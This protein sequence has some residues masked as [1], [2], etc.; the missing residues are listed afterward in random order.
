MT[1]QPEKKLGDIVNEL[2]TLD[3]NHRLVI[4]K[5]QSGLYTV[6]TI[7]IPR[8]ED[9]PHIE[10][11]LTQSAFDYGIIIVANGTRGFYPGYRHQFVLETDIKKFVMHLTSGE[12]G[13]LRGAREGNYL[14]HPRHTIIEE[15]FSDE[16]PDARHHKDSS[17]KNFYRRHPELVVGS[18]L[19]VIRVDSEHY[20]LRTD[21]SSL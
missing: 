11:E 13:I 4:G 17:F 21:R 8:E 10:V 9:L 2:T 15:R 20:R 3:I 1:N 16:V 6:K 12:E 19:N 7:N 5:T 14:C 18:T